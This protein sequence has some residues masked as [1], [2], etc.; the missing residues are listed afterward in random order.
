MSLTLEL[1]RMETDR[2]L[3]WP[4]SAGNGLISAVPHDCPK[5]AKKANV[6][7]SS[8]QALVN[9][10]NNNNNSLSKVR[11]GLSTHHKRHSYYEC[12]VNVEVSALLEHWL[13]WDHHH[14]SDQ[15]ELVS[16][17]ASPMPTSWADRLVS[18]LVEEAPIPTDKNSTDHPIS[19][20]VRKFCSEIGCDVLKKQD[21]NGKTLLHHLLSGAVKRNLV[22]TARILIEAGIAVDTRDLNGD[23]PLLLIKNLITEL[24]TAASTTSSNANVDEDS[25]NSNSDYSN[26]NSDYPNS[27]SN[28][29]CSSSPISEVCDLI[30]LLVVEH[31]ASLDALDAK[32]RSLLTY[33][34][35]AGDRCLAITRLLI[36]LGA[37][38]FSDQLGNE[39]GSSAFAWFLRAQMRKIPKGQNFEI[40][41][42]DEDS[43]YVLGTAIIA[44]AHDLGFKAIVDRT[45]V[46]LGTSR[47]VHGPLFRRLRGLLAPYWLQPL[48][49]RQLAVHSLRRSLGP[50]RLS[51]TN[52]KGHNAE[53][54]MSARLK[55]PLK[56]QRYIMLEEKIPASK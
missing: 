30:M 38:T 27:N 16:D 25:S 46:A 32:G 10:N 28:S 31:H 24:A 23:T 33:A 5:A 50:K 52:K 19:I 43:L 45:M 53:L 4:Y 54:L 14:H 48:Q 36:N 47:E 7:N 17:S 39:A 34:V 13:G 29:S 6:T 8:N 11:A 44:E 42:L 26:S 41:D 21:N 35:E 15:S 18:H 51:T 22:V 3:F 37:K 56:L 12:C 40:L 9:N 1:L 49:L 20:W 2:D 55:V